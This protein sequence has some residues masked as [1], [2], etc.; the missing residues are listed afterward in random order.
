MHQRPA[1]RSG[2]TSRSHSKRQPAVRGCRAVLLPNGN[3]VAR[4]A[5]TLWRFPCRAHPSLAL[6]RQRGLATGVRGLGSGDGQRVR[7]DR[8]HHRT[9]PSA[10]RWCKRG[11]PDKQAIGRSRGG[12]STKI[13]ATV[14]AL[15]N[16]TGFVL[17]PGQAHDLKGADVLLEDAPAQ[18]I[19][20]D[21]Y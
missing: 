8:C 17:T 12:L 2:R 21:M 4:P 16:P 14:D 15:G 5:C 20:A 19:L 3:S 7:D 10:Q 11:D 13:H 6:E 9:R 1:A 18:T